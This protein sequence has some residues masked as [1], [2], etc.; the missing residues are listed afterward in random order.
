METYKT[1]KQYAEYAGVTPQSVYRRLQTEQNAAALEGHIVKQHGTTYLDEYAV[2]YLNENRKA[3]FAGSP[4]AQQ[5]HMITELAS[6]AQS[7]QEENEALQKKLIDAL[8]RLTAATQSAAESKVLLADSRA[9]LKL[10]EADAA[11]AEDLRA[12]LKERTRKLRE[13]DQ[14]LQEADAQNEDLR[15]HIANYKLALEE[16]RDQAEEY[17]E[18]CVRNADTIDKLNEELRRLRNRGLLDRIF[19]R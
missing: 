13:L 19:N 11:A 5:E 6:K 18:E 3:A 4:A 1:I 7:L 8:E 14:E 9:R 15:N 2:Q 17:K 10:L 12:N 16:S